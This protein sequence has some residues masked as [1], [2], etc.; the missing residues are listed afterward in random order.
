MRILPCYLLTIPISKSYLFTE[1]CTFFSKVLEEV[2]SLGNDAGI[3]AEQ[4]ASH[5]TPALERKKVGF[6][7]ND[8][9]F[10][11]LILS[12]NLCAILK[13]IQ[14]VISLAAMVSFFINL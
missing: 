7:V 14:S 1:I 3:V 11:D 9:S 12:D 6:V 10:S 2:Y 13:P 4:F 8:F 5:F